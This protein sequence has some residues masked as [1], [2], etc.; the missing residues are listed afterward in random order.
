LLILGFGAHCSSAA[1]NQI[2]PEA[3][4]R[5]V[6]VVVR[7]GTQPQL[8]KQLRNFAESNAFAIRVASTTPSERHVLAQMWRE[9]IKVIARNPFDP[10][11]RISFYRNSVEPVPPEILDVL[12]DE[13]KR[14]I[15]EVEGAVISDKQ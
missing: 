6:F 14:S 11:F 12:V 3:P 15:A 7:E 8:V 4:I 10:E 1:A 2:Q 9:D 13:L 5:S